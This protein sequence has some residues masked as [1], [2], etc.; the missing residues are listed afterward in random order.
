MPKVLANYRIDPELKSGL[1]ALAARHH[2]SATSMLEE[3]LR[4]ALPEGDHD[5][6][7]VESRP[8]LP[9]VA[10]SASAERPERSGEEAKA[11]HRPIAARTDTA[12]RSAQVVRTDFKPEAQE[13]K[14]RRR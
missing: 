12:P 1:E 14:G 2:R 7:D 10:P 13:K 5:A 3:I 4:A 6:G 11:A 9:R 8:S